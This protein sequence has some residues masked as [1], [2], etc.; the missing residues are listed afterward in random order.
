MLIRHNEDDLDK[1]F[2]QKLYGV[3]EE[4][5]LH[6]WEG[7]R[8][9]TPQRKR[10]MW[11]WLLPML[12]LGLGASLWASFKYIQSR[13]S[14]AQVVVVANIASTQQALVQHAEVLPYVAAMNN[15]T[16]DDAGITNGSISSS[17]ASIDKEENKQLA[18]AGNRNQSLNRYDA[19]QK[20][21]KKA[22][23]TT[24]RTSSDGNTLTSP[25][26]AETHRS[27]GQSQ[28]EITQLSPAMQSSTVYSATT[29]T[30]IV[31]AEYVIDSLW[32][33][34]LAVFPMEQSILSEDTLTKAIEKDVFSS[35]LPYI[36]SPALLP[37]RLSVGVYYS[38]AQPMRVKRSAVDDASFRELTNRTDM[39]LAH[40][41]GV[42]AS[43]RIGGNWELS[44]GLEYQSFNER[45]HWSDTTIVYQKI[46]S[47]ALDSSYEGAEL[48]VTPVMHDSTI[49]KSISIRENEVSNRYSNIQMPLIVRWNYIKGNYSLGLEGGAVLHLQSTYKGGLTHMDWI[50][51]P[52]FPINTST[53]VPVTE[54]HHQ[55]KSTVPLQQVYKE[56]NSDLHFGIHQSYR[57]AH[58]WSASL[59]LQTRIMISRDEEPRKTHHRIIQPGV[60]VGLNYFIR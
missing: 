11:R 59:A 15:T 44:A 50:P 6:L 38:L 54:Y 21:R 45:H 53:A 39:N 56:W 32:L 24:I 5:P 26:L 40:G 37:N 31:N 2:R 23:S 55:S 51:V 52:P 47:L 57:F 7:V 46:Y 18:D 3:E 58:Q 1:V 42:Q 41:V 27:V 43:Y 35:S 30:S 17:Y 14:T 4:A 28:M 13:P 20:T 22:S 10:V 60:R 49:S 29:M 34:P 36:D 16:S 8:Q 48:T 9:H 33:K 25:M 19:Q 12:L